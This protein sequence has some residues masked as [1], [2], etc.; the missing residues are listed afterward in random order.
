MIEKYSTAITGMKKLQS[1]PETRE[2]Q[3]GYI[4]Y[5]SKACQLF[6][7]YVD[8]QKVVPFTNK[9]FIPTKKKLEE[10]DK[11]NK[12]LDDELKKKFAISKHKHS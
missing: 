8:A 10:L 4:E 5:F 7:D 12:K 6:A 9:T 1:T 11:R 2:L 3:Q